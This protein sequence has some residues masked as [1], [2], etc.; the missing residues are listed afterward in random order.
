MQRRRDLLRTYHAP[1]QDSR[2]DEIGDE[3]GDDDQAPDEIP[4]ERPVKMRRRPGF[5]NARRIASDDDD[6]PAEKPEDDIPDDREVPMPRFK[7]GSRNARRPHR[8]ASNRGPRC[9]LAI[10]RDASGPR[11]P[12]ARNTP[13]PRAAGFLHQAGGA[14]A[15][16]LLCLTPVQFRTRP[17]KRSA[18][19]YT[20]SPRDRP[21]RCGFGVSFPMGPLLRGHLAGAWAGSAGGDC[22][23]WPNA[24]RCRWRGLQTRFRRH[25][26]FSHGWRAN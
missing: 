18:E 19:H 9:L 23:M 24:S 17:E 14:R 11:T 20:R 16:R 12:T 8:A 13:T 21:V 26:S 10:A 4:E 1:G 5:R 25:S 6:I 2:D 15:L 3:I 22:S 7:P